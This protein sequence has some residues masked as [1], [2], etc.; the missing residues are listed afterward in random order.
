M[1]TLV[2]AKDSSKLSSGVLV[3]ASKVSFTCGTLVYQY[4]LNIERLLAIGRRSG[5]VMNF[6]VSQGIFFCRCSISL[7]TFS[8]NLISSIQTMIEVKTEINL[9]GRSRR[10]NEKTVGK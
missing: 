8:V 1:L 5:F 3:Q 7:R 6:I 9:A 2:I 4:T 10:S